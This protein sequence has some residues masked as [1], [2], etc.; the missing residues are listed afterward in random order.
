MSAKK[1]DDV[2]IF[3]DKSRQ[4]Y[5]AKVTIEKGKPRKTVHGKTEEEVLLKARQ[6]MYSTRDEK[7][8]EKK[9][10]PLID[11]L[12]MNFERKDEAG[13]IGDAQYV[14]TG[15]VIKY[16]ENSEIGQKNVLDLTEKDYQNFFNNVAKEYAGSSIDKFYAEINQALKYAKR[17]KIISDNFLED[18]I[19]PKSQ[20]PEK[21]VIPLTTTQQKIFSDYLLN[22]PS[23]KCKYKNVMLI[24]LYMGLRIG[25]ALALKR[26]DIDLKNKTIHVER[27]VTQGRDKKLKLGEMTKTEAGN[28][29]LPIP[30]IIYNYILEQLQLISPH[31]EALLF[32]NNGKLIGH[33]SVNDQMK[34]RLLGL[35]IY[36]DGLST[37]SLRHTYATRCIE[38]GMQPIVLSKLLGHSDIRITLNTYVKI[39]NEYKTKVAK[40]VE[41]Y[42]EDLNLTPSIN[43]PLKNTNLDFEDLENKGAKIIQFP[44]RA[45]NDYSR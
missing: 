32:S 16:I 14:R 26:K 23:S 6:L 15:Y 40:E 35:H 41:N 2:A 31:N 13:K 38:S 1:Y 10:I 29:V 7:F 3:F 30:D 21:E 28:R 17:K 5:G 11:L 24:Q 44:K 43:I 37:H 33:S 27:T 4:R 42:Y 20:L 22:V 8:M 19:R 18:I 39:F 9:G 34:R 25:E 45:I 12:K 36:E